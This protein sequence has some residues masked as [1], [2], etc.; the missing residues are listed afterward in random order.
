MSIWSGELTLNPSSGK[1]RC[2]SGTEEF[3]PIV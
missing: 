1:F 2:E 3:T